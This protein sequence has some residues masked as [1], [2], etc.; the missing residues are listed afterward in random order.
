MT[1]RHPN[2]L[3]VL[4]V[5]TLMACG[6]ALAQTPMQSG[7]V[8]PKESKRMAIEQHRS[9]NQS[10]RIRHGFRSGALR[11]KRVSSPMSSDGF[12]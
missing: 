1:R 7:R 3:T 8:S 6:F 12:A 9:S 4:S 10:K 5:M 11:M 2:I